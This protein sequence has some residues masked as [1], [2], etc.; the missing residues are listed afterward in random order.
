MELEQEAELPMREDN[1][2]NTG[3]VLEEEEKPPELESVDN[4]SEGDDNDED[5]EAA[6]RKASKKK[7]LPPLPSTAARYH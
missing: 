7:K 5:I 6:K 3:K 1:G 4:F 2:D